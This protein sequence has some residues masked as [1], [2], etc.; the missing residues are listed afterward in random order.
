MAN[1]ITS[2]IFA[3][4]TPIIFVILWL[5][6]PIFLLAAVLVEIILY[7][8]VINKMLFYKVEIE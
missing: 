2:Y 6:E 8:W 1:F 3:I 4:F 5:F 7:R